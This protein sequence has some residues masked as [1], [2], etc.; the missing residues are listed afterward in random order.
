[1]S[2]PAIPKLNPAPKAKLRR[3]LNSTKYG[4]TLSVVVNGALSFEESFFSQS[5]GLDSLS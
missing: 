2:A 1:M 4:Q 3:E 5:K